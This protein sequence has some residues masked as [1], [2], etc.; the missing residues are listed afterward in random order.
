MFTESL[1][2]T[3][4]KCLFVEA[5]NQQLKA[6]NFEIE[7]F[8]LP[9]VEWENINI[10]VRNSTWKIKQRKDHLRGCSITLPYFYCLKLLK[11]KIFAQSVLTKRLTTAQ[12]EKL[13]FLHVP[14]I[15]FI[16]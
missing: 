8:H 14:A 16:G 5:N 15:K 3:T 10:T 12:N 7:C 13:A 11:I 4:F 2:S 1:I 9:I 6:N